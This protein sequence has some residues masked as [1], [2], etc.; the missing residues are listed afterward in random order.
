MTNTTLTTLA[1]ALCCAMGAVHAKTVSETG[2]GSSEPEACN[3][4]KRSAQIAL[5]T[6]AYVAD[7]R[8]SSCNCQKKSENSGIL[9]WVCEVEAR[10]VDK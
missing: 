8:Y 7:V 5:G 6:A 1:L 4:A 2:N 3:A 9:N 10:T